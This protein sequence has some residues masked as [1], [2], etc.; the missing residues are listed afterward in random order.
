M[1]QD[2]DNPVNIRIDKML[3]NGSI[4]P[5]NIVILPRIYYI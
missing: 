1:V 5:N 2:P 3:I 4:V